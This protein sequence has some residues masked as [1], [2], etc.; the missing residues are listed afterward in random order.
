M[1]FCLHN[2]YGSVT[3]QP[4][5]GSGDSDAKPHH[6]TQLEKLD[7]ICLRA[8]ARRIILVACTTAAEFSFLL[9]GQSLL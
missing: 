9:C 6:L 7:L 1:R 5:L 4:A 8:E 3:L 2:A